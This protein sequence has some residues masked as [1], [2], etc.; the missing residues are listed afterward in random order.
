VHDVLLLLILPIVFSGCDK[1]K[2]LVCLTRPDHYPDF[3][4]FI[5][6]MIK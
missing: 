2:G 5:Q 4:I 6:N 1:A 3:I